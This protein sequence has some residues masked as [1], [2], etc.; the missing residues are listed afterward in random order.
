MTW[1]PDGK[2]WPAADYNRAVDALNAGQPV[3]AWRWSV[4]IRKSGISEDDRAFLMR[5][6]H[7]RGLIASGRFPTGE[8]YE[9]A[10]WRGTG[11]LTRY[12]DVDWDVL[13]PVD[14]VLTVEE[15]KGQVPG[16]EW[17]RLQGSGVMV[18]SP[19]D[20]QLNRL[21][22]RHVGGTPYRA[23]GEVT[24]GG[25]REGS[26][27]KV[28]VNRYERDRKARAA[29]LAHHGTTCVVC[30]FNFEDAYGL[31]GR[32]FIHVHHLREISTLGPGYKIDPLTELIPLCANCHNM[33]H[34]RRP[35]FSPSE[36][37]RKLKK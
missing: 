5:Q 3:K 14:D 8:I 12:V 21:W 18:K 25:Y 26:I 22:D 11:G 15:L 13:L 31:I 29:C 36:L 9:R 19:S 37:R 6:H 34:R 4:A 16:V 35:A 32:N 28:A 27:V 33:V 17:D 23:P 2:G 20:A 24:P 30:K 1:D 10:D 7:E